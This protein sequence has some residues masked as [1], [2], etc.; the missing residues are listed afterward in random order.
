MNV[1]F[2]TFLTL[3]A[4]ALAF[5]C[6]PRP[7]QSR[8]AQPSR[9]TLQKT[10]A[11]L[12]ESP[13][14]SSQSHSA[15]RVSPGPQTIRWLLDED[16]APSRLELDQHQLWTALPPEVHEFVGEH[17]VHAQ[18]VVA[19]NPSETLFLIRIFWGAVESTLMVLGPDGT[20]L[21]ATTFDRRIHDLGLVHLLGNSVPEVV[22]RMIEGT[23]LSTYPEWWEFFR[24]DES[25][26]LEPMARVPASMSSGSKCQHFEYK[27]AITIPEIGVLR[28][29]NLHSND[30]DEEGDKSKEP[31]LADLT[32]SFELHFGPGHPKPQRRELAPSAEEWHP[33][34]CGPSRPSLWPD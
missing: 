8:A 32:K 15:E 9:A 20:V 26:A 24:L 7:T 18:F 2:N 17:E 21:S 11:P 14:L 1:H 22:V 13:S 25:G 28:V 34:P 5:S 27:N 12:K 6:V 33:P 29:V 30:V 10:E 31:H 3:A 16:P 23:A 19:L 4:G